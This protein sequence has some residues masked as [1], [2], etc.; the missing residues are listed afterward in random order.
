MCVFDFV[1]SDETDK[2]SW[3]VPSP[4]IKNA[5][6]K[7]LPNCKPHPHTTHQLTLTP[8]RS[9]PQMESHTHFSS[10]EMK[11]IYAL[12][13]QHG[14]MNKQYEV[15]IETLGDVFKRNGVTLDDKI[16]TSLYECLRIDGMPV[17]LFGERFNTLKLNFITD[18]FPFLSRHFPKIFPLTLLSFPQQFCFLSRKWR[19]ARLMR[20]R[21][22]LSIF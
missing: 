15:T 8:F 5:I 1:W 14:L 9:D 3:E 6:G 13:Q 11:R 7:I 2:C 12:I 22:L 10:R 21:R 16:V 20:R 18:F 19:E 4:F 17:N